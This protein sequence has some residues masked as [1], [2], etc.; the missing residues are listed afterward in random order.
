MPKDKISCGKNNA[1]TDSRQNPAEDVQTLND[2]AAL[3]LAPDSVRM[4]TR[5]DYELL[6]TGI[7]AKQ[8][9]GICFGL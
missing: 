7:T 2:E 6:R 4:S 5:C 8:L 3:G 9:T 1:C